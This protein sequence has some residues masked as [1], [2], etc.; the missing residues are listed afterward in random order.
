MSPCDV[1]EQGLNPRKGTR[2]VWKEAAWAGS[3][4]RF[5]GQQPHLAV[6]AGKG[7]VSPC[8]E[9]EQGGGKHEASAETRGAY[10]VLGP[11]RKDSLWA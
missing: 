10:G 7:S 11:L 1:F 6:Q 5:K 8:G 2:L 9:G 3:Q 4:K